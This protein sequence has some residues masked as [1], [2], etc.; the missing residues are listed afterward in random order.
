MLVYCWKRSGK[1]VNGTLIIASQRA[2]QRVLSY[3]VSTAEMPEPKQRNKGVSMNDKWFRISLGGACGL[4]CAMD[5][6]AFDPA[7]ETKEPA[8]DKVQKIRLNGTKQ[9]RCVIL[10]K[11]HCK[12]TIEVQQDQ[13]LSQNR[14]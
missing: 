1:E 2:N 6:A 13:C 3:W 14:I 11:Q 12:E 7:S 10:C 5:A 8:P 9:I 4:L